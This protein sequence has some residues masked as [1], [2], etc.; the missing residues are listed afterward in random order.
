LINYY[1][2]TRRPE[3]IIVLV[4]ADGDPSIEKSLES[5]VADMP[6]TKVIAV[7][8][9]EFE[10]WLL[11]VPNVESLKPRE[12]K[13]RLAQVTDSRDARKSIAETVELDAL[14]KRC[15]S[16]AQCLKKLRPA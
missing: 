6:G 16:F 10:A 4:D 15:P 5:D 1:P 2:P 14:A 9:Q 8:V 12:A 3:L 13:D 7:A 11:D